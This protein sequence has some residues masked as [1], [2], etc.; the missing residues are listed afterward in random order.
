MFVALFI[1]CYY[2]KVSVTKTEREQIIL[3]DKSKLLF[4][5]TTGQI[6]TVSIFVHKKR[7]FESNFAL[8]WNR[9]LDETDTVNSKRHFGKTFIASSKYSKNKTKES[10]VGLFLR[11]NYRKSTND[12]GII[13]S[14]DEFKESYVLNN[15]LADTLIFH[16]KN[17]FTLSCQNKCVQRLIY[18]RKKGIIHLE[19]SDGAIWKLH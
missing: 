6:D 2:P 9:K 4:I 1:S 15:E 17:A 11:V 7:G 14:I 5:N 10:S 18:S 13:L 8:W 19:Q 16:N 12:E 3:P